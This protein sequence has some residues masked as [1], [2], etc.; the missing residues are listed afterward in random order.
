[1]DVCIPS[2]ILVAWFSFEAED[3]KNYDNIVDGFDAFEPLSKFFDW[4]VNR[5]ILDD[6]WFKKIIFDSSWK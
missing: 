5:L 3:E 4:L 2:S 6:I 1:M